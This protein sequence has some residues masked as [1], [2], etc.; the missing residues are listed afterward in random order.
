[1]TAKFIED[2]GY[3]DSDMEIKLTRN[4]E[5]VNEHFG[6]LLI[7][8]DEPLYQKRLVEAILN[9]NASVL[10]GSISKESSQ[11]HAD[12]MWAIKL[13][14]SFCGYYIGCTS[15]EVNKIKDF[16]KLELTT[17]LKKIIDHIERS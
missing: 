13:I 10:Q 2:R 5:K 17:R 3:T 12:H 9:L 11:L 7:S 14:G 1:M 15:W 8:K 16:D 6:I 4:F